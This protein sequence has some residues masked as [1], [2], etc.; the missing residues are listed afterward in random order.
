MLLGVV[1]H[2]VIRMVVDGKWG[3][4]LTFACAHKN[5]LRLSSTVLV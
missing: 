3:N 1:Y 5:E 2:A 4:Y